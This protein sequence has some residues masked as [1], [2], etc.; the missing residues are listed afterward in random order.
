ML[1][2]TGLPQRK[3]ANKALVVS[4]VGSRTADW[5]T[6]MAVLPAACVNSS[7]RSTEFPA[8]IDFVSLHEGLDTSMLTTYMMG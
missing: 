3:G 6:A 4:H 7:T 5:V 1:C 2:A 8:L